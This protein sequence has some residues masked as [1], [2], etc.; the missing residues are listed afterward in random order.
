MLEMHAHKLLL[1]IFPYT[2]QHSCVD[3]LVLCIVV[4]MGDVHTPQA[5]SSTQLDSNVLACMSSC[6]VSTIGLCS[7]KIAASC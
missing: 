4:L 2:Q 3:Q 6:S 7:K 5:S 1:G